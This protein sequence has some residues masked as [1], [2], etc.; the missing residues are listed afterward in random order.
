MN[1]K[2]ELVEIAKNLPEIKCAFIYYEGS[3]G[4]EK[5]YIKNRSFN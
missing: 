4:S 3:D 1:A 2:D 5:T